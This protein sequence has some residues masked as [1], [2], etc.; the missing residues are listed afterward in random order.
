MSVF[1]TDDAFPNLKWLDISH[2]KFVEFPAFKCPKLE[3]LN[4][5]GNKLE[6]V[7]EAWVGH[8]KLRIISAVDN[9]FKSLMPFKSMAKLEELYMA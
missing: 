5:S 9:K 3:Y 1:A 2:N 8:E 7:N 6:K 4:I